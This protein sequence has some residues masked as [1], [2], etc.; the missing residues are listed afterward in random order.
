MTENVIHKTPKMKREEERLGSPLEEILPET[1][2]RTGSLEATAEE[3]GLN[4]NTLYS[5]LLRMGYTRK[6]TL[7]RR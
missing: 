5:W 2:E 3:L 6:V 1:Y 4:T 7:V